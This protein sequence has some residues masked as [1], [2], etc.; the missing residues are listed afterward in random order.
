MAPIRNKQ[1]E[2]LMQLTLQ[3]RNRKENDAKYAKFHGDNLI[4]VSIDQICSKVGPDGFAEP[5]LSKSWF[6][7]R[8]RCSAAAEQL[9]CAKKDCGWIC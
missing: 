8:Y 1:D 3:V 9:A 6:R 2:E 7:W 4:G 5:N